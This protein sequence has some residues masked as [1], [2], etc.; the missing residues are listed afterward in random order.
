MA[1][2]DFGRP[3]NVW[4]YKN[5]EIGTYANTDDLMETYTA[6]VTSADV[7]DA[8]GKSVYDSLKDGKS[9]LTTYVDGVK[10]AV[11][12]GS[13]DSYVEK[14]D[15]NTVNGSGNGMLTEVYLDDD[16]NVTIVSINTYV[17]QA[18]A[19]YSSSKDSVSLTTAGDTDITLD[20]NTL[21]GD[22][23]D[24]KNIKADD[25]I[26]VNAAKLSNGRYDVKNIAVAEVVTGAVNS[27]KLDDSV[28][29]G[30][31]T[32]KYA[33]KTLKSTD[34]ASDTV[35]GTQYTVGQ[36]AAVVLDQYGYIIAV[37]AAVVSSN[38]VYVSEFA[39]A[40]RPVLR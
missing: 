25:Y 38:Y 32:Y 23:F 9:D 19:D 7:Y 11:A 26:L 14:N 31:T 24:I 36:D 5:D 15:T 39:Q 20:N 30:S 3:S 22:D 13:V 27:Y 18:V 33:L 10:T 37:D 35:K 2:D 34:S 17:F 28:T 6:K 29:I 8:V 12:K 1:R 21:D 40:L 4:E 16:N